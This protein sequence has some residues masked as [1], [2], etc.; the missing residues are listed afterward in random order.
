MSKYKDWLS[1]HL[2]TCDKSARSIN[3]LSGYAA[4]GLT[5]GR[6]DETTYNGIVTYHAAAAADRQDM[7]CLLDAVADSG[8]ID[9]ME[10]LDGLRAAVKQYRAASGLDGNKEKRERAAKILGLDNSEELKERV[11]ARLMAWLMGYLTAAVC[12]GLISPRAMPDIYE[13]ATADNG[14]ENAAANLLLEMWSDG[15]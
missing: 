3:F 4:G 8:T 10:Y 13:V 5:A 9:K 6:M 15:V 12:L 2:T 1:Y 7:D 14:T 11:T